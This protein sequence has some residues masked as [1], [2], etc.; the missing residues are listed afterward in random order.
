MDKKALLNPRKYTFKV[1]FTAISLK[2]RKF[3]IRE[4]YLT[5]NSRM[6]C[7]ELVELHILLTKNIELTKLLPHGAKQRAT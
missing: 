6:L 3:G 7:N 1:K 5:L 4:G 2:R